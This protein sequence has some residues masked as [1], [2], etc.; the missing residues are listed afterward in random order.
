MKTTTRRTLALAAALICSC[1]AAEVRDTAL[2]PT[3]TTAYASESV[4]VQPHYLQYAGSIAESV[5]TKSDFEK[6]KMFKNIICELAAYSAV[7]NE[8]NASV[9]NVFD[10]VPET[11]SSSEGY[12]NAF[13]YL[14]ELSNIECYII[15]GTIQHNCK[16]Y[17]HTWN[18]VI[19]DGK[20][21]LVDSARCDTYSDTPVDLFFLKGVYKQSERSYLRF[22]NDTVTIYTYSDETIATVPPE[23]L[24]LSHT[25]YTFRKKP[26][27]AGSGGSGGSGYSDRPAVITDPIIIGTKT[28][29]WAAIIDAIRNAAEGDTI[30][31][32]MGRYV[33]IPK[34]VVAAAAEA[35]ITLKV[36]INSMFSW[37]IDGDSLKNI[38]SSISV[39]IGKSRNDDAAYNLPA[40]VNTKAIETFRLS[41]DDYSY[42]PVLSIAMGRASDGLFASLFN[43]DE[44]D[45]LVCTD[46]TTTPQDGVVNFIITEKGEYAIMTSVETKLPGD[47]DNS[48]DLTTVDTVTLLDEIVGIA[49]ESPEYKTDVNGDSLINAHDA[50][51]ILNRMK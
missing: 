19:L 33:L 4:E 44:D 46:V 12:A 31:I 23:V 38:N 2:F 29:G 36:V 26:S 51:A 25:D 15:R 37:T 20:S 32:S 8:E 6:L 13:M 16:P 14:C 45:R 10:S 30:S 39:E 40:A 11:L 50:A 21:Y 35:G 34:E 9:K 7:S 18:H 48:A 5:A 27:D 3:G 43:S 24:E 28:Q 47:L 17:E 22:I 41:A 42:N 1:A 49:G